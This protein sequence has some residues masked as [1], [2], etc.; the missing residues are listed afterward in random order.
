ME[1]NSCKNKEICHMYFRINKYSKYANISITNCKFY[2]IINSNTNSNTNSN[3]NSITFKAKDK[4]Y[5]KIKKFSDENFKKKQQ[6]QNSIKKEMNNNS[7]PKI[8]EFI[9]KPLKL[10]TTCPDCGALTFK[11]DVLKCDLCGKQICSCCATFNNAQQILC[12]DCWAN[13]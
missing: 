13:Y 10:D 4:D 3:L 9:A 1:C 2:N 12:R 6:E 5:D 7:T 8:R 11:E